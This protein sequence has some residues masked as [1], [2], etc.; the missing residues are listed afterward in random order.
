MKTY[1]LMISK[2]FPATH[3]LAGRE[4]KFRLKIAWQTK[5]H[6][7]RKNYF[8]WKKRIDA[9]N[10][11]KAILS[12]REWSGKPYN[13]KQVEIL[14]FKAGDVSCQRLD[15]DIFGW[16]IDGAD[17]DITTKTIASNDGL[18]EREFCDWFQKS[19]MKC[20]AI[21]HFRNFNY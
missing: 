10:E 11:G 6:T 4:T 9:V 16:F 13:T 12:L 2:V 7:I 8:Y 20:M 19:E 14:Q 1:V 15:K 3:P 21:I 18:T 5:V 17:S